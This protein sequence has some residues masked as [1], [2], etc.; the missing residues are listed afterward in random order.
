MS[1][2][3]AE[4]LRQR[5]QQLAQWFDGSAVLWSGQAPSRNFAANRYP[6]R[7]SSHF[8]YFAGLPLHQA[9]IHLEAGRLTLFWD[10]PS[11]D[12]ALW[13][14]PQPSLEQV[15]A[16]IGA[17]AAY[18][19]TAVTPYLAGAATIAVQDGATHAQQSLMLGRW[20]PQAAAAIGRD[21]RLIEAIIQLRLHHDPL[22]LHQ[23]RQAA[24]VTVEAHQAGLGATAN[25]PCAA[26]VRAAMEQVIL[27]EDMTCAYPSIVTPQGEVLHNDR[28]HALLQPGDLVLADVGA[29]TAGGWAADVTRTWP[30]SGQFSPSQRALY[31]L[32]LAAHDCCL[33]QVK[34]GVEYRDLHW[35]A[36]VVLTDGLMDLG[37]LQ[38]DREQLLAADA[39]ALF[40]PHGLGHL[41]GL[42]VHDMEDLG[43]GAGYAPGRQRCD[44]MGLKYLR[45]NRPLAPGMVV[46]IEPGFYQVPGL[47]QGI[48]QTAPYQDWINWDKLSQFQDVRGIRIENDVLITEDGCEV[49]TAALPTAA[50]EIEALVG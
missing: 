1:L 11:P 26:T 39:H 5:R 15:A 43:D 7:A 35:A 40:F 25:A 30:V 17:D 27:A 12:A 2:V 21:R 13:H 24:A 14:G 22:A 34:P 47:L 46:T 8:L 49:L 48:A 23:L 20:I 28:Y 50:A 42:D 6:F 32:V 29:E 10:Q 45:L 16:Q 4:A 44:R 19:L 41:L 9:M 3:L 37:I 38:G 31:D 36:A 33:D 18:P